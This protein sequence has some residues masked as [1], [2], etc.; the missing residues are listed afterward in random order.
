MS[1]L[2]P[3]RRRPPSIG[4]LKSTPHSLREIDV[5]PSKPARVPPHGSV[6]VPK[7]STSRVTGLVTPLMVR[8]PV[9]SRPLPPFS[10]RVLVNVI[11]P[12]FSTSKKS[13]ERRCASRFSSRVLIELRSIEA[14]ADGF[15]PVTIW[16]S[17]FSNRPRTL[18]IRWRAVNPISEWLGSM[19]QVP[20][21]MLVL[22]RA[23]L[24][25]SP[26]EDAV[27]CVFNC[28]PNVTASG[29]IFNY[30]TCKLV[31]MTVDSSHVTWLDQQQQRTWRAFLVGTTLLMDRLD[32]DLR[33]P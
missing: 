3:T 8:S 19:L 20:A 21:G 1:I 7:Y 18:L 22:C 4:M 17:N 26:P 31:P 13:A 9:T 33:E 29:S 14:V 6:S 5:V 32:R 10:T 25:G 24:M 30:E 28:L 2:S 27:C 23:V 16:P 15:S 11:G 12:L